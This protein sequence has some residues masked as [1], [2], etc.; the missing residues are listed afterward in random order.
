MDFKEVIS[1]AAGHHSVDDEQVP[2]QRFPLTLL[3]SGET[4]F[5]LDQ[6]NG[7]PKAF[8]ATN[9][10]VRGKTFHKPRND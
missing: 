2:K 1:N 10:K 6:L 4:L 8:L 3:T 7:E 5:F 9:R